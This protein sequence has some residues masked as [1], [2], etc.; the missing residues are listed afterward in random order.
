MTLP[1]PLTNYPWPNNQRT[2]DAEF[3]R[4]AMMSGPKGEG[5]SPIN[6]G[7]ALNIS[8][9][10]DYK[11]ATGGSGLQVVIGQSGST[12]NAAYV[13]G[14]YRATQ[15]LYY[16]FTDQQQVV[17][18]ETAD[19]NPRIDA[20]VLRID[21]SDAGDAN[22]RFLATYVK[23]TPNASATLATADTYAPALSNNQLLLGYVWV[24]GSFTGPF[25]DVTHITDRRWFSYS[26]GRRI[27]DGR[28]ASNFSEVYTTGIGPNSA[29]I[30]DVNGDNVHNVRLLAEAYEVNGSGGVGEGIGAAIYD[31]TGSAGKA[32]VTNTIHAGTNYAQAFGTFSS[33]GLIF[34]GRR[35]YGLRTW[36]FAG[37]SSTVTLVGSS[38]YPIRLWAEYV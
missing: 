1:T 35:Q 8:G 30:I 4:L 3:L 15:G 27:A 19:A 21:D 38:Q 2:Y 16:C 31:I 17:T 22:D 25:V 29:I 26:P 12:G 33:D 20:I 37:G 10:N 14:D 32:I 23:G 34:A 36:K 18:L 9:Y 5:I 11:V 13:E 24:P 28:L 7:T 6:D